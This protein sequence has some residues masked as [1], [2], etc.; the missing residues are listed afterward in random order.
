MSDKETNIYKMK[1]HD[2]LITS[3][4]SNSH[5][6]FTSVM[7]VPGGWIYRS[8]DKGNKIMSSSFVRFYNEFQPTLPTQ[9][10]EL[11]T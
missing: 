2:I 6:L 1:L 5:H 9:D 4:N 3:E 11:A 8:I 10:Y 7:R